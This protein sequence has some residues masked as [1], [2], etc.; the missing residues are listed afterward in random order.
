MI[1]KLLTDRHVQ[2][3][4]HMKNE[5]SQIKDNFDAWHMAN[6]V[7]KIYIK[8]QAKH[9]PELKPGIDAVIIFLICGGPL[10]HRTE[11]TN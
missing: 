10:K 5:T 9:C 8:T 11:M 3:R 6:S 1:S 7:Q 4:A 2:V